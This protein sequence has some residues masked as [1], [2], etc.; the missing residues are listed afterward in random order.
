VSDF[1]KWLRTF[2]SEKELDLEHRFNKDGPS[3]MNSIPLG[4]VIEAMVLAPV[5][6]QEMIRDQLVRLDFRNA[7]VLN[8]FD[9]LAGALAI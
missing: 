1:A 9:H 7:N 4:N 3:G 5:H 8:Y 2:V 6:E